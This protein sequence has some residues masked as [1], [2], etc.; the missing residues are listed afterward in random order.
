MFAGFA[1]ADSMTFFTADAYNIQYQSP[2]AIKI[3]KNIDALAPWVAAGKP[4]DYSSYKPVYTWTKDEDWAYKYAFVTFD[5]ELPSDLADGTYS[6]DLYYDEYYNTN[7]SALF[8]EKTNE[9]LP[10]S[11]K[12]VG[13]T[14]AAGVKGAQKLESVPLKITVGDAPVETTKAPDET[15]KAPDTTTTA[16]PAETTKAPETTTGAPVSA[17]AIIYD[18]VPNG[19]DFTAA[20]AASAGQNVYTATPGEELTIDWTVKNDGGTAGLQMYFDFSEVEYVSAKSG[21]AYRVSPQFNDAKAN[22]SKSEDADEGGLVCYTFGGEKELK[23]KDGA[24]IYSFNVKVPTEPGTY[25]IKQDTRSN[26]PTKVVPKDQDHPY[27]TLVHGLDIVVPGGTTKAPDETTKAPDETTK[28]PDET[29][30]APDETTTTTTVKPDE[31]TAPVQTTT[32]DGVL[33][34]D[35]NCDGSVK[36]NDVVLLNRYLNKTA[37][38]TDQ[39]AKNADCVNDGELKEND[40]EAIKDFLARILKALPKK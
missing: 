30:K 4:E 35:V 1:N 28:A 24:V 6:L 12:T 37:T 36:I 15:T 19:K 21:S 2:S 29:T 39:G 25:S 40:S 11:E 32:P 38:L 31:T 23:A 22:V 8:D 10:D 7:P 14:G 18:L 9:E 34:G 13:Q 27:E 33:F 3:E 16:K 17:D 26:N 5:L 20:P